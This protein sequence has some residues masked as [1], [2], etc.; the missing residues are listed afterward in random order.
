VANNPQSTNGNPAQ[1]RG[2]IQRGSTGDK[3]SGFDPAMAPMETDGEA[4]GTPLTPDQT[5]IARATQFQGTRDKSAPEYSNAMLGLPG[6]KSSA[7][8]SAYL[9]VLLA[10]LG[11]L[12]AISLFVYLLG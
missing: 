3:R 7:R 8:P 11:V 10:S 6:M 5:D 1:I 2:D 12:A 4:A 9:W